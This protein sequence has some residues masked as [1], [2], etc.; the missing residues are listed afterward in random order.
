MEGDEKGEGGLEEKETG[1]QEGRRG[2]REEDPTHTL[3]T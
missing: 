2:G 3:A 1:R